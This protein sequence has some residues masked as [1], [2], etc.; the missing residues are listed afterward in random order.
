MVRS[1]GEN[2]LA[3][4]RPGM[5]KSVASERVSIEGSRLAGG[6][7]SAASLSE[8][9]L[10]VLAHE[11]LKD[12]NPLVQRAAFGRLLESLTSDN[13]HNIRKILLESG[14][15]SRGDEWR[16]FHY[17]WGAIDGAAA[18]KSAIASKEYDLAYCM[19]GFASASPY[20]ARRFLE[21]LSDD[22]KT[23]R[24][25]IQRSLVSGM[26]DSDTG[27]A[28]SYVFELASQGDR[29]AR[30]LIGVVTREVLRNG[31]LGD[32]V[33][34]SESLP[35]GPLKGIALDR[36]AHSYV[37]RDAEGAA[38]WAEQFSRQEYASSVIEEVGE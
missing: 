21:T 26:A 23:D 1:S 10:A 29:S 4:S 30:S 6:S 38:A 34:W 28:T 7:S 33:S 2:G 20:E 8:S 36:V 27:L 19:S 37:E 3:S 16:D 13:A 15:S 11:A 12:G 31:E 17:A 32:A 14:V 35:D 22:V 18:M 5:L 9:A 24:E 25:L